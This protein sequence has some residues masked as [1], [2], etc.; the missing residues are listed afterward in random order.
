MLYN[1]AIL[2]NLNLAASICGCYISIL[3]HRSNPLAVRLSSRRSRSV[4][5]AERIASDVEVGPTAVG[6]TP[7]DERVVA[8]ADSS[9]S[10]VFALG[11]ERAVG[12]LLR[13][14]QIERLAAARIGQ[15]TG[16][17]HDLEGKEKIA[18]LVAG[19]VQRGTACTQ[20]AAIGLL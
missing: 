9:D 20:G 18:V 10:V 8:F 19:I 1:I 15:M 13:L 3:R 11:R 12:E 5:H 14:E 16:F 6:P 17:D 4:E 7:I 2:N